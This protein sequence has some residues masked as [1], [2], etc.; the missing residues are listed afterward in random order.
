MEKTVKINGMMCGHCEA[1]V[2][3]ALEAVAGVTGADVSHEKGVAVVA[4]AQD[5]SDDVLA[6]AVKEAG[7][8]VVGIN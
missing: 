7:Y 2:K 5:V 8:E 3:K 6:G 4:L 1:H